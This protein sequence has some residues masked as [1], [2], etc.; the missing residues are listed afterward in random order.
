MAQPSRATKRVSIASDLLPATSRPT[1]SKPLFSILDVPADCAVITQE[2]V[3]PTE[4][5]TF[6]YA[7]FNAAMDRIG[8]RKFYV[9]DVEC[10]LANP[11]TMMKCAE[12]FAAV[13]GE[14]EYTG[15]RSCYQLPVL[16]YDQFNNDLWLRAFRST[17]LL[18][19]MGMI[20]PACY[21]ESDTANVEGI[22]TVI[23]SALTLGIPV[24]GFYSGRT[25]GAPD[26]AW[27]PRDQFQIAVKAIRAAGARG[28]ILFKGSGERELKKW[29]EYVQLARRVVA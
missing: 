14:M 21:S 8:P 17:G 5:G 19:K 10:W 26:G 20:C 3:D 16:G 27:L 2:E 9:A 22:T 29:A 28:V 1:G 25:N 23:K 12:Q 24:Y 6:D 18:A 11:N 4:S 15:M 7:A 13:L